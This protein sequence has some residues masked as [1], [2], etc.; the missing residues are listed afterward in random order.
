LESDNAANSSQV[1]RRHSRPRIRTQEIPAWAYVAAGGLL[2]LAFAYVAF[3]PL[4]QDR[5]RDALAAGTGDCVGLPLCQD[6]PAIGGAAPQA[7]LGS[8]GFTPAPGLSPLPTGSPPVPP[9]ASAPPGSRTPPTTQAPGQ[10]LRAVFASDL[11]F[12]RQENGFGRVER[13]TSNGERGDGDGNPLTVGG[14]VFTK[15]LGVHA[16]SD[17]AFR[18]DGKCST[19][20]A[21][22]GLDDEEDR[23]T[24]AGGRVVFR[25]QADGSTVFQ[26]GVMTFSDDARPIDVA[27]AGAQ[28]VNL[29]VDTAGDDR[30]DHADWGDARFF[31]APA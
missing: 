16:P 29:I 22:I 25:V 26:S 31:C 3:V 18:L 12:E 1:R 14:K 9:P 23:L 21:S 28:V 30:S 4:M 8:G 6:D 27:V 10:G 13:D 15:G 19:F 11:P 2:T 7:P 5:E 24:S 17:V 20:S